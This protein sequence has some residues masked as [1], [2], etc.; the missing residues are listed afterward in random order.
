[1]HRISTTIGLD[2]NPP[3]DFFT[4]IIL[5]Y[6]YHAQTSF[7]RVKWVQFPLTSYFS[8]WSVTMWH[9]HPS[10]DH[11]LSFPTGYLKRTNSN[12][13]TKKIRLASV[14]NSQAVAHKLIKDEWQDAS[15]ALRDLA[16]TT[17]TISMT[18]TTVTLSLATTRISHSLLHSQVFNPSNKLL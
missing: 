12:S 5:L 9:A 10:Y 6:Y 13:S 7:H 8:P 16:V 1:M 15:L 4:F 14:T 18:S 17:C 3:V 11:G 2:W